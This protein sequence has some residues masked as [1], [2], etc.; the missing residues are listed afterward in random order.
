VVIALDH[1]FIP[2]DRGLQVAGRWRG[3]VVFRAI[4]WSASKRSH[5]FGH[6]LVTVK[7]RELLIFNKSLKLLIKM[8]VDIGI[9]RVTATVQIEVAIGHGISQLTI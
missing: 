8:V 6:N 9:E 3:V 1:N 4:R 2:D 5:N 7:F